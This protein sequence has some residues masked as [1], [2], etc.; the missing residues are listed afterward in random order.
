MVQGELIHALCPFSCYLLSFS[1]CAFLV[2]RKE[3]GA[4]CFM[5]VRRRSTRRGRQD[6]GINTSKDAP[7]SIIQCPLTTSKSL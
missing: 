5:G 7:G 2:G 1:A 3:S 4:G 6:E